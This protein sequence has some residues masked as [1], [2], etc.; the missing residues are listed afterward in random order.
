MYT[1]DGGSS[2]CNEDAYNWEV[3]PSKTC[4]WISSEDLINACDYFSRTDHIIAGCAINQ[5]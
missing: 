1:V 2:K 4:N 3:H 5:L